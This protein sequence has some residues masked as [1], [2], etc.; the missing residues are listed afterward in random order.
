MLTSLKSSSPVLVMRSSM[1]V[2]VCNYFYA[3]RANSGKIT[4][5]AGVFSFA[6]SFVK[7]PLNQL[8]EILSQNAR[9]FMLSQG[10]TP[11]FPSHLGLNRYWVVTDRG[12]AGR[13]ELP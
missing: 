6:L 13:T 12:T 2:P 7:I 5:L 10:E 1:F 4:F 3:R 9:D 11:K 8:H